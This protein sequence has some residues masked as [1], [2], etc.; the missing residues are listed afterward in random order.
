MM[1]MMMM[2]II[3]IRNIAADCLYFQ[4]QVPCTVFSVRTAVAMFLLAYR[5]A[6]KNQQYDVVW[7]IFCAKCAVCNLLYLSS[8]N[9]EHTLLHKVANS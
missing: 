8:P 6:H 2:I 9:T 5:T 1:M 4:S 7:F 3:I